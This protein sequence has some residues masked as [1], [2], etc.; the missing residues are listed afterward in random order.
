MNWIVPSHTVREWGMWQGSMQGF[1]P[2]ILQAGCAVPRAVSRMPLASA[3]DHSR[4]T[5]T[6]GWVHVA[7]RCAEHHR[8]LRGPP[9]LAFPACQ[10]HGEH[11]ATLSLSEP[12]ATTACI[13]HHRP[14]LYTA[15]PALSNAG[16]YCNG[17][18]H[19]QTELLLHSE[20]SEEVL[21]S[22]SCSKI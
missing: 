17:F 6:G 12:L 13:T 3:G 20:F 7:A 5:G 4:L 21:F 14:T 22:T 11:Y 19:L 15:N 2:D 10:L 8:A 16:T 1:G 9:F 18:C